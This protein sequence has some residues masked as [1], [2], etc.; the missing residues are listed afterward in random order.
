M[1]RDHSD[2]HS[3]FDV[4]YTPAIA[5]GAQLREQLIEHLPVSHDFGSSHFGHKSICCGQLLSC[6]RTCRCFQSSRAAIARVSATNLAMCM[7]SAPQPSQ[8]IT[9]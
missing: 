2:E 1:T 8:M 6:H 9:E 4:C 3:D 7:Y 5:K